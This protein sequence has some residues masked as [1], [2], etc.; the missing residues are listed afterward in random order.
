MKS[1]Y[2]A[3]RVER[4][5]RNPKLLYVGLL[6]YDL[7]YVCVWSDIDIKDGA[8]SCRWEIA[9]LIRKSV[10]KLFFADAYRLELFYLF[11]AVPSYIMS[12]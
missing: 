10:F 6:M 2:S 3:H 9:I 5:K 11:H 8:V 12:T 7:K 4:R 1:I